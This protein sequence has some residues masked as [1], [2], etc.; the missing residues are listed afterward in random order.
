MEY[1]LLAAGILVL[2]DG[3]Y[4]IGQNNDQQCNDCDQENFLFH[5]SLPPSVS[6]STRE[7]RGRSI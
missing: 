7:S 3:V 1:F 6:V 4:G 5:Y 2:T